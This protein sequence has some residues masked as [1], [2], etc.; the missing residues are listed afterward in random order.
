MESIN[1]DY[2]ISIKDK[3]GVYFVKPFATK[4]E[5]LIT[6]EKASTIIIRG[7]YIAVSINKY[8]L[9]LKGKDFYMT[10]FHIS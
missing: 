2:T 7:N 9:L 3:N 5:K 8:R 1:K 6:F 4:A 10:K